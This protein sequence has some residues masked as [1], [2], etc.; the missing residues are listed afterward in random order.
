VGSR[1]NRPAPS[2]AR[3]AVGEREVSAS[4][5]GLEQQRMG[6]PKR[7]MPED[8][9][10]R[11]M[12]AT[13][14]K[15]RAGWARRGLAHRGPLDRTTQT[16]LLRQLYL[17]HFAE[18]SFEQAYDIATQ[19]L[20]LGVLPDVIHQDAARAKQATGDIDQ[21]VGHLRLAARLGPPSR[22]A[23]HL[24][25]L[26]AV[27]FLA[28]RHAEAISALGRA[29]RWGTTDKPLYE[30][31]LAAAKLDAGMK[32]RNV[33]GIIDRLARC[34]AGQGYGRLVLGLLAQH[35]E[36]WDDARSYLESFV[37]RAERGQPTAA[38]ALEGEIAL[39]RRRLARIAAR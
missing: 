36:R 4:G 15:A 5:E 7:L 29:A 25:T 30:G 3:V 10:E 9:L 1:S 27:L 19:A 2:A 8:H 26:G 22:R 39:A 28:G 34:P 38:I 32:V 21:A 14:P 23:F 35:A 18:R 24:W 33:G 12:A 13:T 20:A 11:A 31:H 37:A 6:R 16:L 17:A